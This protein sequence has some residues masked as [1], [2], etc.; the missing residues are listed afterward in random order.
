MIQARPNRTL[1]AGMDMD[2]QTADTVAVLGD[3][4]S[5]I[6]IKPGEHISNSASPSSDMRRVRRMW[7]IVRVTW[8]MMNVSS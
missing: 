4:T 3:R 8:A 7:S 1:H 6:V 2:K 5:Q